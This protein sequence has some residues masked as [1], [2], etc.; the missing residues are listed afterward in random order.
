VV[1]SRIDAGNPELRPEQTWSY[2]LGYQKRV[3]M[4]AGLVE[5]RAY[6]DDITGAIDKVPLRDSRGLYSASGNI[7]AAHRYGSE[8]KASLRLDA[9]K[10]RNALLSV[11]YTYQR[12]DVRDPF[13]GEHRRLPGDT[14][15]N[16][17]VTFRH[18]LLG[19]GASYG[20]GYKYVGGAIVASDLLV[21][22]TLEVRPLI[23]AFAEKKLGRKLVLRLEGQNLGGSREIQNRT[24]FVVNAIDGAV[25]RRDYYNER[26]DVRVAV[27][28]RG[29]F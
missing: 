17:E 23:E 13:T 1:D 22:S 11:R 2:E 12:T 28:L 26:R 25:L 7:A 24:L 9:L 10:L 19:Q 14:G 4:D 29:R 5:V 15:N 21:R 6:F 20:F 16:Y 8:L 3:G 18:D 27:R